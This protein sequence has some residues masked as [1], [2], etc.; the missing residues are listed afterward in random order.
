MHVQIDQWMSIDL[1]LQ[2]K[3]N[4]CCCQACS[5]ADMLDS[6]NWDAFWDAFGQCAG[7]TGGPH[8][9]IAGPAT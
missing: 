1:Q 7:E 9:Q 5:D 8:H 6:K 4:V 2:A 3:R